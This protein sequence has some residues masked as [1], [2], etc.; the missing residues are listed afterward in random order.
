MHKLIEKDFGGEVLVFIFRKGIIIKILLLIFFIIILTVSIIP[1]IVFN[2]FPLEY[3]NTIKECAEKYKIDPLFVA[4]IIKVESKFNADALS[5]RGAKG[6]MQL[7]PKTATWISNQTKIKY[8]E[9][10]L[11]IPK[12]NIEF[13]CWYLNNLEVQFEGQMPVILA[14]YN[15]GRGNVKKWLTNGVWDGKYE[16]IDNIPFIQTRKFVK[17]VYFNYEVYK[18]LY[19]DKKRGFFEKTT[20]YLTKYLQKYIYAD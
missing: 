20:N 8:K 15:G 13:G 4:A 18:F 6:L 12:Y 2:L 7:M 1:K 19:K 17:K 3:S 11:Y 14:A 10:Y 9:E 5:K 16:N